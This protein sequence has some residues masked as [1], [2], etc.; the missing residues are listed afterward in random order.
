MPSQRD[1]RGTFPT[2]RRDPVSP[3]AKVHFSVLRPA[4]SGPTRLRPARSL[5]AEKR[6]GREKSGF[7]STLDPGGTVPDRFRE[8]EIVVSG[9]FA[10]VSG[11]VSLYGARFSVRPASRSCTHYSTKKRTGTAKNYFPITARGRRN[12]S[13]GF[14][15]LKFLELS[16]SFCDR[17]SAFR[18]LTARDQAVGLA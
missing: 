2:G 17:L 6:Q 5:Q 12:F 13:Y 11:R 14:R 3:R 1:P 10:S 9:S 7:P 16:L 18:S 8:S 15:I 4:F